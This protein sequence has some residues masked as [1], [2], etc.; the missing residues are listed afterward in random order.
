MHDATTLLGLERGVRL[1]NKSK[2]AST[3]V[4]LCF[5]MDTAQKALSPAQAQV[6]SVLLELS[7]QGVTDAGCLASAPGL[8]IRMVWVRHLHL[9]HLAAQPVAGVILQS[10]AAA[11]PAGRQQPSPAVEFAQLQ[12]QQKYITSS[13]AARLPADANVF[14]ERA[15]ERH[16]VM[17]PCPT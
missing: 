4:L 7:A 9:A 8:C 17:L 6:R 14:S 2:H 16:R 3:V 11:N 5:M 1:N 10:H 15:L 13:A 12:H